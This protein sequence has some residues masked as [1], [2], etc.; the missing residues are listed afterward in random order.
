MQTKALGERKKT[1]TV[2]GIA[3]EG[4]KEWATAGTAESPHVKVIFLWWRDD[5]RPISARLTG[6]AVAQSGV[7]APVRKRQRKNSCSTPFG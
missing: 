7:V 6:F 3:W 2:T 5:C 1:D 4:G